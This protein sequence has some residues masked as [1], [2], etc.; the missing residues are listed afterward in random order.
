MQGMRA[1]ATS[2]LAVVVNAP[3]VTVYGP[4]HSKRVSNHHEDVPLRHIDK[5]TAKKDVP[6][7]RVY[8]DDVDS[9][10]C[11]FV[12]QVISQLRWEV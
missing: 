1:A 9:L 4:R 7:S 10:P 12:S 5:D 6:H 2:A 8:G 11:N 3:K